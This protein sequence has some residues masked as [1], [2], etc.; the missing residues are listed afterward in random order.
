M[1]DDSK[2]KIHFG[3]KGMQDFTLNKNPE[4]KKLYY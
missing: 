2:N 3:A 4:R 1:I